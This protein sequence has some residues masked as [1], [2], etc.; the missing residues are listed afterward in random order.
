MVLIKNVDVPKFD[1]RNLSTKTVY[2][3]FHKKRVQCSNV[4][5]TYEKKLK[6]KIKTSVVDKLK[7]INE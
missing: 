6:L 2:S 3:H 7:L 5:F 1:F 4:D